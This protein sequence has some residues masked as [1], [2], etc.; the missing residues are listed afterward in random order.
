MKKVFFIT[1]SSLFLINLMSAQIVTT[2]D[3]PAKD[4]EVKSSKKILNDISAIDEIRQHLLLD[5]KLQ[6]VFNYYVD[7]GVVK[8]EI[9]IDKDGLI[10]NVRI[11]ESLSRDHDQEIISSI[12]SKVQV[13]PIKIDG[14]TVKQKIVLPIYF[15]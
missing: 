13:S 5:K 12:Q 6:K 2:L 3:P 7:E 4:L 10:S 11:V 15:Q 9:T 14:Q 8:A 1:L